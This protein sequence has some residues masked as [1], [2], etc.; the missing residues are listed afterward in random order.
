MGTTKEQRAA[1]VADVTANLAV[2]NLRA[3]GFSKKLDELYIAGKVTNEQIIAAL[4]KHYGAEKPAKKM[5][6]KNQ[7]LRQALASTVSR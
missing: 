7:E 6:I 1:I 5:P 4:K 2:D 3:A